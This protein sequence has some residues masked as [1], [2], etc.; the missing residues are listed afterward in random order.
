MVYLF[1]EL[2]SLDVLVCFMAMEKGGFLLL[3][4]EPEESENK[5]LHCN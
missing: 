1:F 3:K 5:V 2:R 4:C